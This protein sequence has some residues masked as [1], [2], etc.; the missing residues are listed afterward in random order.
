M[1]VTVRALCTDLPRDARSVGKAG[2]DSGRQTFHLGIQ[3]GETAIDVVPLD[4]DPVVLEAVFRVAE[5]DDGKVNFLGPYAKGTVTE[6]FFYLLWIAVGDG[7]EHTRYG[8]AKIHLSH[9]PWSAVARAAETGAPLAVT[10]SLTDR[11]GRPR[12]GSLRD[13]EARWQL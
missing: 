8:R 4:D 7:G 13:G 3:R 9:L 5:R 1:E 10:L 12:C 2:V 6:R 11:H